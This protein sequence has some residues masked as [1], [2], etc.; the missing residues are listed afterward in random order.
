MPK[1]QLYA[2]ASLGSS[3]AFTGLYIIF[4]IGV[5]SLVEPVRGGAVQTFLWIAGIA[6]L[7]ELL[8]DLGSGRDRVDA[9]E[10][11]RLIA[12]R[13]YRIGFHVFSVAMIILIGQMFVSEFLGGAEQ[14]ADWVGPQ[15]RLA[16]HF[17]V[18]S[19]LLAN[20]A[21]SGTQVIL[22]GRGG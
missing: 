16:R 18:L 10:R 2:W 4:L 11:D 14:A 20:A 7:I 21:R 1:Q 6:F 3:I 8:L 17:A 9:D 22:Y 13:A 15:S 12:G 5:P 19:F